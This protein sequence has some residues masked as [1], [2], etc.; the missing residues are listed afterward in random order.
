[1][2]KRELIDEIAMRNPTAKPEFL[3]R[4]D[5]M[6]L[7]AYLDHLIVA[8][9]PRLSGGG[10]RFAKYFMTSEQLSP[11]EL[12]AW[13]RMPV[14]STAPAAPAIEQPAQPVQ[15]STPKE[16]LQ[17]ISSEPVIVTQ[18]A[19]FQ[20]GSA[21][22]EMSED[23][24]APAPAEEVAAEPVVETPAP[25]DDVAEPE[26]TTQSQ[27]DL[28]DDED[29]HTEPDCDP[30]DDLP[31]MAGLNDFH[32]HDVAP[33][34]APAPSPVQDADPEL[35]QQTI[36]EHEPAAATSA[37]EEVEEPIV[38]EQ[39]V[40]AQ[41]PTAEAVTI[42]EPPAAQS[43]AETPAAEEATVVVEEEQPL[44]AEQPQVFHEPIEY[45]PVEEAIA[46]PL[47]ADL[48]DPLDHETPEEAAPEAQAPAEPAP[49]AELRARKPRA[50]RTRRPEPTPEPAEAEL[51]V[52]D[53]P[54]DIAKPE[55]VAAMASANSGGDNSD[56]W[57]F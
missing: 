53:I 30:L 4:F 12:P 35:V 26:L 51:D 56:S 49:P 14:T 16:E 29:R 31:E 50:K 55:P 19:L 2:T 40:A 7:G 25:A 22:P 6:D 52:L 9:R 1:M 39:P 13:A 28:A 11:G 32:A 41:P 48:A 18:A 21:E 46:D 34:P 33:S 47:D 42:D 44:V 24:A 57:L 3:S 36:E 15:Q 45:V 8:R 37:P 10:N 5:E 27:A 23:E 54:A 20:P 43:P 38:E 17:P